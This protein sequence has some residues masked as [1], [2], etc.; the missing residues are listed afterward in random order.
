MRWCW[1]SNQPSD[2]TQSREAP[3]G[4][5]CVS[6]AKRPKSLSGGPPSASRPEG[7]PMAGGGARRPPRYLREPPRAS[8]DRAGGGAGG[9]AGGRGWVRAGGRGWVRAVPSAPTWPTP[10]R[11]PRCAGVAPRPCIER[12]RRTAQ[13]ARTESH[14]NADREPL[15][16]THRPVN[17]AVSLVSG[18]TGVSEVGGRRPRREWYGVSVL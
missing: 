16:R 5:F 6:G 2:K 10:D 1:L 9:G 12:A 13:A 17:R 18:Q 14:K 4:A 15:E 8:E 3:F 7:G 11:A